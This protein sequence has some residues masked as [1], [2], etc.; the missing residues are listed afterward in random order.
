M[1]E[2]YVRAYRSLD[3]FRRDAELGS[4]LYR[5]VYNA[6][7]DELRR[8]GRRPVPVDTGE[9]LWDAPSGQAGPERAVHAS[10][11]A[12]R[13]LAALPE[14]QRATVLLVDGEGLDNVTRGRGARRRSGHGRLAPVA[15]SRRDAP[16]PRRGRAMT[17]RD[18]RDPRI[19]EALARI[20][21]PDYSPGFWDRLDARLSDDLVVVPMAG[22]PRRTTAGARRGIAILAA[23][24][25]IALAVVA[26]QLAT[27]DG[28]EVQTAQQPD[29]P[30][31]ADGGGQ[32]LAS[33]LGAPG[34]TA[35]PQDAFVSWVT[36]VADGDDAG[37][38]SLL[39]PGTVAYLEALGSGAL[40]SSGEG[41][42]AWADPTGRELDVID[43]GEVGGERVAGVVVRRPTRS[44][45][46]GWSTARWP[47]WR[48]RTAGSWSR[49]RS[50]PTPT[51]DW[52]W[53]SR[54]RGSRGWC[55]WS[56]AATSGSS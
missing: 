12:R 14:D 54:W 25:A 40:E 5:I 33:E 46:S 2:A 28:G 10:D 29:A 49:R 51:R 27:D 43:F 3:R 52:R 26:V 34:S 7:I 11:S 8:S 18:D 38:R 45:P 20:D 17:D 41:W 30:A 21:V 44:S 13:A 16:H 23:A 47:R 15:R 4:W 24:A 36:A 6:C 50:T 53:S 9:V 37:A 22:R 39:G 32:R 55:R 35:T 42:E 48:R 19:A 56:K 31:V 1:Q